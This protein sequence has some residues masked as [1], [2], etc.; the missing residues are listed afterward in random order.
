VNFDSEAISN[1]ARKDF[2]DKFLSNPDYNYE[3][4]N[5]ASTACGPLVKWASAQ[6]LY[7]DMLKKVDPLRQELQALVDEAKINE[8]ESREMDDIIV[9]LEQKIEEYKREYADLIG[10]A[11]SIKQEM[12]SVESKVIF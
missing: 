3:K 1:K 7:S 6:L 12:K 2:K 10:Q 11:E 4:I 5:K 9:E 8:D